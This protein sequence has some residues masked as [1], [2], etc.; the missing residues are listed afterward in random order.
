MIFRENL[1]DCVY[2][3][4]NSNTCMSQS[5][6]I[7]TNRVDGDGMITRNIEQLINCPVYK[8]SQGSH[9]VLPDK[10]EMSA[11]YEIQIGEKTV[12]Q[13]I[14]IPSRGMLSRSLSFLRGGC[15]GQTGDLMS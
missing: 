12:L 1:Q 8:P 3:G 11:P 14:P 5:Y 10:S 6:K 7:G 13:V 4:S 9:A 15:S 2:R